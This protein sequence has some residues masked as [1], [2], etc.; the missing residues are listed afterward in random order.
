MMATAGA[1]RAP[2]R[3]AGRD[4]PP[5]GPERGGGRPRQGSRDPRGTGWGLE[6]RPYAR[7]VGLRVQGLRL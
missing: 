1:V 7:P 4:E 5:A 2:P 3:A 6:N